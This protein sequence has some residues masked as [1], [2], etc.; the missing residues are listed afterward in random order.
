MWVGCIGEVATEGIAHEGDD[1][2][3]HEPVY[4]APHEELPFG[5][6]GDIGWFDVKG[7]E[8][9]DLLEC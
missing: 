9:G 3:L 4:V 8:H 1:A 6:L 5:G 2:L 7:G